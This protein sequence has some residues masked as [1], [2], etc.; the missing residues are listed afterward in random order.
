MNTPDTQS[1]LRPLSLLSFLL[2]VCLLPASLPA[3]ERP[4]SE[5]RA[6][7][8]NAQIEIGNVRGRVEVEAWDRDSIEISGTLAEGAK[9]LL[10]EGDERRL[11]VKVDHPHSG[12]GR[13]W[14]GWW[15]GDQV[16]DSLLL[17]KLPRTAGLEVNTVSADIKV[18]DVAGERMALK[19]VSGSVQQRG[20]PGQ[21]EIST[22][23]GSQRSE[24]SA[25]QVTLE[26]VSG[27]IELAGGSPDSLRAESVSGSLKLRLGSV[28]G[29]VNAESV[30]GG[31]HL[32]AGALTGRIQ[33]ESMSG[34]VS[35]ELPADA[36][37]RLQVS[38]FSGSI[39]SQAGQVERRR[40]GPGASLTHT[41][42]GGEA[43]VSVETFSGGVRIR[44]LAN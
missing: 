25:R 26:T 31:I 23:S 20:D 2:C 28:P 35:L 41:L 7:A 42:G 4:I 27:R 11:S 8:P 40:Y 9:G 24:T 5:S 12:G 15:G 18:A 38:S 29:S 44:L 21:L 22:V 32:G 16:G 14:F 13:G 17:V 37:A 1:C 30:S 10:I 36:S 33:I 34:S 6:V 39:D 19:S 43:N 3:A